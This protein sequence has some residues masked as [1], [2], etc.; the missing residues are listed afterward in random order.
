M[1]DL[2]PT[3]D[4]ARIRL[5]SSSALPMVLPIPA[6]GNASSR[7]SG[8]T[9]GV[10]IFFFSLYP[11]SNRQEALLVLPLY[12]I[13]I[14]T[15]SHHLHSATI[16]VQATVTS[17]FQQLPNWSPFFPPFPATVCS[18]Y[19]NKRDSFK[20]RVRCSSSTQPSLIA[21]SHAE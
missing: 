12:G 19:R 10:I 9:L 20:I 13:Q 16:L 8:Q 5:I 1:E 14:P 18:H 3:P 15:I 6:D 17:S 2:L 7:Q 21:R 4:L 11:T